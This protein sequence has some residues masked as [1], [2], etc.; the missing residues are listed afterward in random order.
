MEYE[1]FEVPNDIL[2]TW[3]EIGEKGIELESGYKH[4]IKKSQKLN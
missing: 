4:L 1:P 3:R 2:N